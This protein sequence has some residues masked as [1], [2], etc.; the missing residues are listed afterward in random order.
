MCSS[1]AE[2]LLTVLV[3]S[4]ALLASATV[5][6]QGTDPLLG[7]VDATTRTQ[8][9]G[10]LDDANRF[11]PSYSDTTPGR[12]VP[13][14]SLPPSAITR[15]ELDATRV[16]LRAA[17]S[18]GVD[19]GL[20]TLGSNRLRLGRL[21]DVLS[22]IALA[23]TEDRLQ[24]AEIALGGTHAAEFATAR[25]DLETVVVAR[26]ASISDLRALFRRLA[27]ARSDFDLVFDLE[28]LRP[29]TTPPA[30][31]IVITAPS[32]GRGNP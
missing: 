13:A 18:I 2:R 6:A 14:R 23:I 3:F 12:L 24:Q 19:R 9:E 15:A 31:D 4:A 8:I 21:E 7:R 1:V 32:N 29:G 25:R 26:G 5:L 27:Y 20:G 17:T 28:L 30:G 10:M 22:W 11:L 16:F